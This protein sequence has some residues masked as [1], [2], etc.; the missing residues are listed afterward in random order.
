MNKTSYKAHIKKKKQTSLPDI[1]SPKLGGLYWN[2]ILVY[3]GL[4]C[5]CKYKRLNYTKGT[6]NNSTVAYIL[7]HKDRTLN[8]SE[9]GKT[10]LKKSKKDRKRSNNSQKHTKKGTFFTIFEKGTLIL[11]TIACKKSLQY[12]LYCVKCMSFT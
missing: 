12:A 5:T 7:G 4:I 6:S 10:R 2:V 11:T 1:H 3:S 9:K 8:F